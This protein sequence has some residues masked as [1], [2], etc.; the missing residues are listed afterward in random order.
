MG[1]SK[2]SRTYCQIWSD[3][4][5]KTALDALFETDASLHPPVLDVDVVIVGMGGVGALV[6][7]ILVEAG[8]NVVGLEAGPVWRDQDFLPDEL[9]V[10]YYCRASMGEKFELET[11]RWRVDAASH[12]RLKRPFLLGG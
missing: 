8:L 12:R 1:A 4:R 11:P 5:K 10:A 9:G 2:V 7:P 6:A 3:A